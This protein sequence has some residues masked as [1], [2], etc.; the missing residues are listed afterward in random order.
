MAR[1]SAK[2]RWATDEQTSF[3]ESRIPDFLSAQADGKLK[4]FWATL[5]GEWFQRWS[6]RDR[7]EPAPLS[8]DSEDPPPLSP[9]ALLDYQ[10]ALGNRKSVSRIYSRYIFQF[11]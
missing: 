9:M 8:N 11:T 6:E 10:R 5:E 1:T 2:K 4:R 3:L 7:F